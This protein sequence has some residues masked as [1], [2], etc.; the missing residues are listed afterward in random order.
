MSFEKH[1]R[2]QA[3]ILI[4][5]LAKTAQ[6]EIDAMRAAVEAR[7]G[8]LHKA[9]SHTNQTSVLDSLVQELSG[10][11]NEEAEARAVQVRQEVQKQ[12][13]AALAAARAQAEAALAA[14]RA[15]IDRT[16][17][18]LEARLAEAQKAHAALSSTL[19]DAQKQVTAARSER[20]ARAASLEELQERFR[21]LDQERKQLLSAR[22]E[23]NKLL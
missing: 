5:A 16:R 15:D 20:D 7:T 22:D 14:A 1:A 2:R 19:A 8:A 11:A 17:K 21:P 6:T 23:A 12:A 10:A 13:E 18:E 4:D 3:Q 9:L